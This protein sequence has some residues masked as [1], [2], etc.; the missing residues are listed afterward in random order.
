MVC[1]NLVADSTSG[2]LSSVSA[3]SSPGTEPSSA[4]FLGGVGLV[5]ADTELDTGEEKETA[6]EESAAELAVTTSCPQSRYPA[7]CSAMK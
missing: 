4:D 7:S 6:A 3:V 1:T 2:D 5:S